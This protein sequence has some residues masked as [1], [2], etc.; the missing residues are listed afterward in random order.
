VRLLFYHIFGLQV[1]VEVILDDEYCLVLECIQ[2][3]RFSV[4]RGT[5]S[6]QYPSEGQAYLDVQDPCRIVVS[7]KGKFF[8]LMIH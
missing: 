3:C 5:K 6:R 7:I 2:K 1:G 8:K 4:H